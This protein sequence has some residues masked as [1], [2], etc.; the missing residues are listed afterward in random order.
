VVTPTQLLRFY[1]RLWR[2]RYGEEFLALL[3]SAP[4]TKRTVWDVIRAAALE[5]RETRLGRL[6]LSVLLGAATFATVAIAAATVAVNR[7]DQLRVHSYL[8]SLL[9]NP[10][11]LG[12]GLAYVRSFPWWR[13]RLISNLALQSV[14]ICGLTVWWQL[15]EVSSH[16]RSDSVVNWWGTALMCWAPVEMFLLLGLSAEWKRRSQDPADIGYGIEHPP[17]F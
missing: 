17:F 4:I 13:S 6:A 1:P 15:G 9:T 7:L 8:V 14:V 3:A 5:W 16:L 11:V 10:M 2:R 12:V